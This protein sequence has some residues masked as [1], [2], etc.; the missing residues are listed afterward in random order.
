M[1]RKTSI[2][3]KTY[4]TRSS[5][6]YFSLPSIVAK[7]SVIPSQLTLDITTFFFQ[8]RNVLLDFLPYF[9]Q[10]KGDWQQKTCEWGF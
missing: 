5:L 4:V 8:K 9:V 7:R 10:E 1:H 6:L 2:L 3:Q